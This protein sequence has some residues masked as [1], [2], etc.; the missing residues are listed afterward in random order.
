MDSRRSVSA[1][2]NEETE[3]EGRRPFPPG[4][5]PD[6]KV[7]FRQALEEL[8]EVI[9]DVKENLSEFSAVLSILIE[10]L[11]D[12]QTLLNEVENEL[13]QEGP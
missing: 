10:H 5:E 8:E 13:I 11:E 12:T 7:Q 4:A 1:E 2:A 3:A 9:T 6:N